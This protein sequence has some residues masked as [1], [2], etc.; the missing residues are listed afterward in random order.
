MNRKPEGYFSNIYVAAAIS[1][2]L[3]KKYS[4]LDIILWGSVMVYADATKHLSLVGNNPVHYIHDLAARSGLTNPLDIDMKLINL[5][6]RPVHDYNFSSYM[7]NMFSKQKICE[8]QLRAEEIIDISESNDKTSFFFWLNHG[9]ES[10]YLK[11]SQTQPYL[12]LNISRDSEYCVENPYYT[13]YCSQLNGPP[14]F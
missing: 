10:S 14:I 4:F 6:E 9:N 12:S 8:I 2:Y 1:S 5:S 11:I 13:N 7:K 3:L